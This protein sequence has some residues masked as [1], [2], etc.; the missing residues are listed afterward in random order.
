MSRIKTGS[1]CALLCL[2]AAGSIASA[3]EQ[4]KQSNIYP[5]F[6]DF[7]LIDTNKDSAITLPEIEVYGGK[8]LVKRLKKCDINKDS[9]VSR[10]EY[11]ACT[12][13]AHA[14]INPAH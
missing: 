5:D 11:A 12:H 4:K 3:A 7:N 1:A 8:A 14:T 2:L 9:S 13:A 10:E 6:P